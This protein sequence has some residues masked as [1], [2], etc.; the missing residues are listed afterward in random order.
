MEQR[1]FADG[2]VDAGRQGAGIVVVQWRDVDLDRHGGFARQ[3]V[4][5]VAA[6]D[7]LA[8]DDDDPGLA[9]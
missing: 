4:L 6:E 9:R 2:S 3:F 5:D 7:R 8:A 1:Q